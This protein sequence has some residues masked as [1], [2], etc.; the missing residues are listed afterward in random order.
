[1]GR[2]TAS[3]AD[4]YTTVQLPFNHYSTIVQPVLLIRL[5]IDKKYT[6]IEER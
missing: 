2:K 5:H 1:M 3:L 6:I 4:S